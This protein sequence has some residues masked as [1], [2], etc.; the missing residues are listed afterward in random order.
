MRRCR[1]SITIATLYEPSTS[2]SCL[3]H[4]RL[5][6]EF[7]S[8]APPK[9]PSTSMAVPLP[10]LRP[11]SIADQP[12]RTPSF[13][14]PSRALS[15]AEAP[16]FPR[17]LLPRPREAGAEALAATLTAVAPPRT[18][19]RR[20]IHLPAASPMSTRAV[21]RRRGPGSAGGILL[22]V[23]ALRCPPAARF[24]S[25]PSRRARSGL[26]CR[27]RPVWRRGGRR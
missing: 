5:T 4:I 11:C 18:N 22:P 15:P 25:S 10:C 19:A 7:Y 23:E 17:R 12:R 13:R 2:K 27:G 9:S 6:S 16:V 3:P 21:A 24:V 20:R 8:P 1:R 26:S 14:A